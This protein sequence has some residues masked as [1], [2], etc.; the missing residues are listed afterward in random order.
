MFAERLERQ[1]ETS[2]QSP[3]GLGQALVTKLLS[4]WKYEGYIRWL[5]GTP[6]HTA[7]PH[8]AS[9]ALSVLLRFERALTRRR[10]RRGAGLRMQYQLRRDLFVDLLAEEFELVQAPGTGAQGAWHGRAVY[11]AYPKR[12]PPARG[13]LSF[14]E[15]AGAGGG[16]VRRPLFSFVPPAAGMFVWVKLHFAGRARRGGGG[17]EDDDE[18]TTQEM[19]LWTAL[20]E[21]G[22]LTAPGWFFAADQEDAPTDPDVEG[23][24]RMSFSSAEVRGRFYFYLCFY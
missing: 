17:D 22:V 6:P 16:A 11:T 23:H 2:T 15:K 19:R 9:C 4:T 7:P 8:G 1:G 18:E 20:A 12:S 5:R 14:G 13:L 21:A 24:M 3:C 10:V